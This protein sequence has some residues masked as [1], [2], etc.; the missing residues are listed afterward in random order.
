MDIKRFL[1]RVKY[2]GTVEP[3]LST[4]TD[5]QQAFLL[6]VPFENLDI[7]LGKKISLSSENLFEKIVL[8][9]RGGFCYECNI[10]FT[11]L[12]EA[13]GYKIQYLS[14]RMVIEDNVGPEFDHM[15]LLVTLGH[16]DQYLV[17]VG[18]GQ[19]ARKPLR[20]DGT[21]NAVSEG[22]TYRVGTLGNDCALIFKENDLHWTP[23]Y[24]FTL[25]PRMR[26]DFEDMCRYHQTSV[27]SHF[28]QHR[29]VTIAT[30]KGRVSLTDMQLSITS[31]SGTQERK[32]RS[33]KEYSATL[34]R[35]FG[36][37]L[38]DWPSV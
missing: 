36:I 26:E 16:D 7:H 8:R 4:L 17:D 31:E 27:E 12:L 20:I 3:D 38:N 34:E 13:L 2:S 37:I 33:E 9:R 6:S 32:L 1:N 15:V 22:R 10:L 21:N 11:D 18:N 19:S 29:L 28:T 23:R 30:Q 5:L 24:L 14:A 25:K 35:Y